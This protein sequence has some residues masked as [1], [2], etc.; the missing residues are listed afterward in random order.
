M[1]NENLILVDDKVSK[2]CKYDGMKNDRKRDS[3]RE[4]G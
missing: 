1:A 2:K 3:D 4:S